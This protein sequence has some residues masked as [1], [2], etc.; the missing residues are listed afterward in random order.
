MSFPIDAPANFFE[1]RMRSQR[2]S[3]ARKARSVTP[4]SQLGTVPAVKR[5]MRQS[6]YVCSSAVHLPRRMGWS[7]GGSGFV[8]CLGAA[9]AGGGGAAG[10]CVGGAAAGC[11]WPSPAIA[12]A[13]G[14][15]AIV[16]VGDFRVASR[17]A[18]GG[19]GEGARMS[20]GQS[21]PV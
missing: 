9:A 5:L 13:C 11:F 10:V 18:L 1:M 3:L 4:S 14:S 21:R 19:V 6:A 16:F 12:L 8:V 7:A 2:S 20:P 15:S 17:S